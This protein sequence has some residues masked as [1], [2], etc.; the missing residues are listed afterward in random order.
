M[1]K[2]LFEFYKDTPKEWFKISVYFLLGILGISMVY[3]LSSSKPFVFLWQ[4]FLGAVI[5]SSI[6]Y[7]PKFSDKSGFLTKD[8]ENLENKE[9]KR[10]CKECGNTWH[11]S[12]KQI[13]KLEKSQGLNA[14]VGGLTALSGNLAAST[15]A[16]GNKETREDKLREL[17]KCPECSSQNYEEKKIEF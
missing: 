5:G 11:V 3:S 1:S 4:I 16:N 9:Y 15:Q 17:E 10:T 14:L 13:Q 2:P 6:R 12:L 7:F 8:S